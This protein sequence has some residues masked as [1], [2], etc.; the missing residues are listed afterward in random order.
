M[1]AAKLREGLKKAGK[2]GILIESAG[3]DPLAQG[4]SAATDWAML[5]QMTK[6]SFIGHRSRWLGSLN[7]AL[8]ERI[9][10]MDQATVDEVQKFSDRLVRGVV[11][12]VVHPPDGIPNPWK[13]GLDA[14]RDCY[15]TICEAVDETIRGLSVK[16]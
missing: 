1:F 13:L 11:V 4:Q 15:Q 12:E 10:C 8:Y 6:V 7:L 9:Y 14:Y 5:L 3:Y 2:N 16:Q